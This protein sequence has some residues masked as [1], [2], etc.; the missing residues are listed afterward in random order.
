MAHMSLIWA[1]TRLFLDFQLK[2][3]TL[4]VYSDTDRAASS[5]RSRRRSSASRRKGI[6]WARSV[7]LCRPAVTAVAPSP[8]ASIPSATSPS[9]SDSPLESPLRC[10]LLSSG[11]L[12][13]SPSSSMP[14]CV[15]LRFRRSGSDALCCSCAN[16]DASL[17]ASA[18]LV[19]RASSVAARSCAAAAEETSSATLLPSGDASAAAPQLLLRVVMPAALPPSRAGSAPGAAVASAEVAA[20]AAPTSPMGRRD[21]ICERSSCSLPLSFA[22]ARASSARPSAYSAICCC[23]T[24][25]RCV[26]WRASASAC[27]RAVCSASR[28]AELEAAASPSLP[29]AGGVPPH[30][31][32][33]SR[34]AN[35]G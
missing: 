26:A 10:R 25:K 6:H 27:S 33:S 28:A 8:S 13:P 31:S 9:E 4:S 30:C 35:A 11:A 19:R 14:A 7:R 24:A 1:C 5:S 29:A 21:K 34:A 22:R 12:P 17:A 20:A 18:S 3:S 32:P 23:A 2:M 16:A 15:E